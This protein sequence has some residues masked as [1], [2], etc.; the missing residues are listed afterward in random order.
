MAWNG[1]KPLTQRIFEQMN[2]G[3][4]GGVSGLGLPMPEIPRRNSGRVVVQEA[5]TGNSD[6]S[7]SPN[8]VSRLLHLSPIS[9]SL[10]KRRDEVVANLFPLLTEA[11]E[12]ERELIEYRQRTLEAQLDELRSKCRQQSGVVNSLREKLQAGE[13]KLL[14]AMANAQNEVKML[15][16]FRDLKAEGKHVPRWPTAAEIDEFE[17]VYAAQQDKVRKANERV[18]TALASRNE[19]LYKLEPVEKDME[20]L[21][22]EEARLKSEVTKQPFIDLEL[23]LESIPSGYT[24]D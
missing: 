4:S 12:L 24:K 14:N 5:R 8:V 9:P 6:P 3:F 7:K 1:P 21:I 2:R 23:G 19:L 16:G 17:T 13:L 11:E 10:K 18:G 15:E 22:A 20:K